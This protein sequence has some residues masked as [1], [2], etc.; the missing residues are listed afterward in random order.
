MAGL[1]IR[2]RLTAAFAAAMLLMLSGAALFVYL[3]LRA[4]LDDAVDA[5]LRARSA[6][7][8]ARPVG[9]SLAWVPLEDAEESFVQILD[10]A[11]R[12][13]DTAGTAR[14]A[15][16]DPAQAR[17]A[18]GSP[19]WVERRVPGVDG[20]SRILARGLP[21]AGGRTDVVVVGQSLND[22]NEALSGVVVSF[23][24]G[25]AVAV[26]AAS[27]IGYLIARAGLAPV[28]RMRRRALE[29]SLADEDGGLPL[30]AARDEVRRLGETLNAMLARLRESFERERRFVDDASHELRTPIAVVKTELEAALLA[31]DCGPRARECLVAALDEC[32]QLAQ[33]AEDLLV[34]AR[35]GE[36][37]L[38]VR[39]ELLRPRSLLESVRDRFADRAARHERRIVV[40]GTDDRP[41]AADPQRLRQALGNLVDNALRHGAGDV[42]L[43]HRRAGVGVELEVADDGPG[44]APEFAPRAFER[45]TRGDAL[46]AHGGAGLGLAIVRAVATS[47]GGLAT[48]AP[49]GAGGRPGG[50]AVRIWLPDGGPTP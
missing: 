32:D 6:A 11:G 7:V 47:H 49:D 13:L 22:R 40:T 27:A 19:L 18:A 1:P 25:G 35:A 44:F 42:V 9:V 45:F 48:I 15:A 39:L 4:D 24:A 30:P 26:I 43:S 5:R 46:R 41:L 37:G 2:V 28:E 23:A 20:P 10:P 8:A 50:A 12:V 16:L 29:V 17:A 31:G 21:G 3:R 14:G 38:P 36:D 34:T 33:L